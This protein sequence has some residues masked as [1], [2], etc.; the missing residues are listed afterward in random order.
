MSIGK[1]EIRQATLADFEAVVQCAKAAYSQ[2][3]EAMGREPAPMCADF[4][5]LIRQGVVDI[6]IAN[7]KLAGFIVLYVRDEQ[8]NEVSL[9]VENIAVL[10]EMSGMGI[11]TSLMTHAEAMAKE[12]SISLVTLYTN[13]K[14]VANLAWYANLGFVE[15]D[16]IREDGFDRVYF[17]KKLVLSS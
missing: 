6:V 13:A 3:V 14:M 2:Y 4:D 9:F 11:G 12:K 5:S 15:T 1:H 16:R 17:E 7:N 8:I 10:P